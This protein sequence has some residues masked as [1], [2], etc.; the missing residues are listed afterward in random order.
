MTVSLRLHRPG[1]LCSQGL[2]MYVT[3]L[4]RQ[5]GSHMKELGLLC[6]EE[7]LG[8]GGGRFMWGQLQKP[9]ALSYGQGS[10][11]LLR[12]FQGKT[13]TK[14]LEIDHSSRKLAIQKLT[15][16]RFAKDISYRHVVVPSFLFISLSI[17]YEQNFLEVELETCFCLFLK[18]IIY[19]TRP[20]TS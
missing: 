1:L 3:P 17:I 14:E 19:F 11:L 8:Q 5:S 12:V 6:L 18:N 10:G 9:E 4:D 2:N 16:I 20:Q 7:T 15:I 13:R